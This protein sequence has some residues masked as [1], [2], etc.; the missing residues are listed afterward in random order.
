M[1]SPPQSHRQRQIRYFCSVMP[2][3]SITVNF[4][5]LL[6]VRSFFPPDCPFIF[7][8]IPYSSPIERQAARKDSLSSRLL[9]LIHFLSFL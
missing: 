8:A 9:L 6:P 3:F 5:N 7:S 2:V 1:I 4:P